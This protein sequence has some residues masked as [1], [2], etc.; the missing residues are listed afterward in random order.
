MASTDERGAPAA[1][2]GFVTRFTNIVPLMEMMGFLK[3]HHDVFRTHF[4]E[5]WRNDPQPLK[6]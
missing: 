1:F 3:D 4:Y 5:A 6:A 2:P